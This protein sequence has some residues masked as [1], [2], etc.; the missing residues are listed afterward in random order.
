MSGLAG[1]PSGEW[2][3]ILLEG[4]VAAV[5]RWETESAPDPEVRRKEIKG[6]LIG[7]KVTVPVG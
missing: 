6:K 7:G 1:L 4:G 2:E 3:P 5:Y